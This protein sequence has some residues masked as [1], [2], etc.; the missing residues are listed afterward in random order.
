MDNYVAPEIPGYA[1]IIVEKVLG[2]QVKVQSVEWT[3]GGLF[4]K[5]F[6]IN[7]TEGCFVLKIECNRIL[8]S[9]RT[10]QMETEVEGSRIFKRADINCPNILK[11]DFT[12]NDI[13][14]RYIFTERVSNDILW[15]ELD[16]MDEAAKTEIER[17]A[18][19]IA[20]KMREIKNTHFGSLTPSGLLGWHKTW[21]ECYKAWFNLIIKDSVEI[22]LFTSGEFAVVKAAAEAPLESSDKYL[23]AFEHGDLG[24]HNMIWGNTN[25]GA[26]DLYVID[27]GNSK[28]L[29]PHLSAG[30]S[31]F[32]A[33]DGKNLDK[34]INLLL[35]YDFEMGVMWKEM[36][37]ITED[38]AHCTNWLTNYIETAKKDTSRDHITEFVEKCREVIQTIKNPT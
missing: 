10:G 5:V 29:P 9:T 20:V 3:A 23:P 37:K 22:E 2:S 27:F 17:K 11:Y 32:D 12:G 1:K 14:V 35:L 24:Y 13:G 21:A 8:P 16:K 26:D 38:Y 25:N 36:A 19:E 7:T 6:Y 34:G 15:G 4:N 28:Y 33:P 30:G 31:P 18:S